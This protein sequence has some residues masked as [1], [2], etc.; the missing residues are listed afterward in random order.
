MLGKIL[1]NVSG[2]IS[3]R[4]S[5]SIGRGIFTRTL[6]GLAVPLII[7]PVAGLRM[8]VPALRAGTLR[9]VIFKKAVRVNSPTPRGCSEL[10]ITDSS[11]LK[12][13]TTVLRGR[14]FCA[15]IKLIRADWS[16]FA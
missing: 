4:L 16:G 11:M 1:T 12:A 9:K 5:T 6:A 14:S 2:R 7:Y 15:A 13:L 3:R 8:S 10:N